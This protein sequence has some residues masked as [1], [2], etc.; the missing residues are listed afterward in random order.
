MNRQD[1]IRQGV[2]AG[3]VV[4]RGATYSWL[5]LGFLNEY[6]GAVLALCAIFTFLSNLVFKWLKHRDKK[7]AA[8]P[9]LSTK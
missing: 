7:D 3:E 4:T 1:A 9:E 5:I 2:E 6:S 8:K